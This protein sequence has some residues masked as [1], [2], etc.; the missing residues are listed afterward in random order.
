MGEL[1]V[2]GGYQQGGTIYASQILANGDVVASGTDLTDDV[3]GAAEDEVE[4]SER[5]VS[6]EQS[7]IGISASYA[8]TNGL[9]LGFQVSEIENF[10][11]MGY[12]IEVN[13]A[14]TDAIVTNTMF[15]DA[16][17]WGVGAAYE[18][19]AW[20]VA[21]NYG[22]YDLDAGFDD[23]HGWGATAAYDFGGGLSAHLGYGYSEVGDA[24]ADSWSFGLA[25]SF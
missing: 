20:T 18:F 25:M 14:G 5:I 4:L 19:D 3:V 13:D 12:T 6:A 17:H 15:S 2:G 21:A 23:R 16:T 11:A 24:D 10:A 1:T 22:Q 8:M 9:T 7:E